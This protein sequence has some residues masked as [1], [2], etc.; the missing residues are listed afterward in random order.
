MW[1]KHK[2][3]A[4]HMPKKATITGSLK[5]IQKLW[6]FN[7][8]LNRRALYKIRFARHIRKL[9]ESNYRQNKSRNAP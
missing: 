7:Y 8:F 4:Q 6:L 5:D 9:G 2:K 1:T 3:T